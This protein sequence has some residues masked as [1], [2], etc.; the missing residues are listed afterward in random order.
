ITGVPDGLSNVGRC[1]VDGQD[2]IITADFTFI[3]QP[4]HVS[5]AGSAA[6]AL[7]WG[8]PTIAA[9]TAPAANLVATI[10]IDTWLRLVTTAEDPSLVH[11]G[12]G[13][14]SCV[15]LRRAFVIRVRNQPTGPV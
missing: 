13:T 7:A 11:P 6:L 10:Y 15:R 14:E 1:L 2:V 12:L 4:L 3:S 8:I 5:Q 9:L